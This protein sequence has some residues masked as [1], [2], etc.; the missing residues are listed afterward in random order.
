MVVAT[1]EEPRE[2]VHDSGATSRRIT[3][4]EFTS[5][6]LE[7]PLSIGK[8][9]AMER[10]NGWSNNSVDGS[11]VRRRSLNRVKYY[12]DSMESSPA[13]MCGALGKTLVSLSWAIVP[14]S[15]SRTQRPV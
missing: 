7:S 13:D 14:I 11:S 15:S 1:E 12:V 6:A 5:P 3:L 10:S 2:T 9:P 4:Q 8:E